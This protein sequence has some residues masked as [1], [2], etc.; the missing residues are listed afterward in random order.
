MS[1]S[2]I[3]NSIIDQKAVVSASLLERSLVGQEA[4][5]AGRFQSLNVGDTSQVETFG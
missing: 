4:R 2:V 1:D 5:V 3:R